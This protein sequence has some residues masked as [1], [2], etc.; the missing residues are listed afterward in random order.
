MVAL[1]YVVGV[2]EVATEKNTCLYYIILVKLG[3]GLICVPQS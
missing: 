3:R 1:L 2:K